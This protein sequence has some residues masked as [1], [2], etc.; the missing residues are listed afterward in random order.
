MVSAASNLAYAADKKAEFSFADALGLTLPVPASSGV[1]SAASN[2]AALVQMSVA[3]LTALQLHQNT[4]MPVFAYEDFVRT[5][6]SFDLDPQRK[7]TG[8]GICRFFLKGFCAKGQTCPYK[9]VN[10]AT[11]NA[12]ASKAGVVCKH[13]L[14]SLCKKGDLCEFLHEY[15]LKKMPECWFYSKYG[16]CSNP[17]CQYLHLDPESKIKECP[18]YARGFCKHGPKCRNKHVRQAVC[19]NYVTGFCPKGPDCPFGHPKFEL[20]TLNEDGTAVAGGHNLFGKKDNLC[21][22][23]KQPGHIAIDC[24]Q[25]GGKPGFKRDLSTIKCYNCQSFAAHTFNERAIYVKGTPSQMSTLDTATAA[26]AEELTKAVENLQ[27]EKRAL[28]AELQQIKKQAIASA[29]TA[30]AAAP[31]LQPAATATAPSL[32]DENARLRQDAEMLDMFRGQNASLKDHMHELAATCDAQRATVARLTHEVGVLRAAARTGESGAGEDGAAGTLPV[33]DDGIQTLIKEFEAVVSGLRAETARLEHALDASQTELAQEK[34]KSRKAIADLQA[35]LTA[36][37]PP[38]A[39]A[40]GSAVPTAVPVAATVKSWW[41]SKT[42]AASATSAGSSAQASTSHSNG[43][44]EISKLEDQIKAANSEIVALKSAKQEQSK[45][46][47]NF[48]KNIGRLREILSL[49]AKSSNMEASLQDV[50]DAVEKTRKATVENESLAK[51]AKDFEAKLS[52]SNQ[53]LAAMAKS[54]VEEKGECNELEISLTSANTQISSL[55]ASL[56]EQGERMQ[57]LLS[58]SSDLKANYEKAIQALQGQKDT[59]ISQYESAACA[60]QETIARKSL[61][62][63]QIKRNN[64]NGEEDG[65]GSEAVDMASSPEFEGLK[66]Q[67]EKDRRLAAEKISSLEAKISTLTTELDKIRTSHTEAVKEI[68]IQKVRETEAISDLELQIKKKNSELEVANAS[69]ENLKNQLEELHKSYDLAVAAA[70]AAKATE[71]NHAEEARQLKAELLRLQGDAANAMKEFESRLVEEKSALTESFKKE[72]ACLEEKLAEISG[73]K[74]KLEKDAAELKNT[75][76]TGLKSTEAEAKTLLEKHKKDVGILEERHKKELAE[77]SET[78][79]RSLADLE[80][81]LKKEHEEKRRKEI[82]EKTAKEKLLADEKLQKE[83]S[84]AEERF[85]KEKTK[86]QAD[87]DA[88]KAEVEKFKKEIASHEQQKTEQAKKFEKEL[89]SRSDDIGR[90]TTRIKTI[91]AE[92]DNYKAE[93][94][95]SIIDLNSKLTSANSTIFK[96]TEDVNEHQKKGTKYEA[97]ILQLRQDV[98]EAKAKLGIIAAE[99]EVS[100]S[101]SERLSNMNK[102]KDENIK[103]LR[104]KIDELIL[105]Q[106]NFAKAVTALENDKE[107]LNNSI[108]L[109]V[110]KLAEAETHFLE[111]QKEFA[112]SRQADLKN[113]QA[114]NEA[115]ESLKNENSAMSGKL[116]DS[117]SEYKAMEKRGAL[118]IKDLQKQII[119]ERR[120]Q[121]SHATSPENSI[122]SDSIESLSKTPDDQ[123]DLLISRNTGNVGVPKIERLTTELVQ[124]AKE[125]ETLNKRFKNAEEE[126]RGLHDRLAKQSEEL[127]LKSKAVQQYMLREYHMQL[128]PDDKQKAGVTMEALTSTSAMQKMNPALLA[129]VNIKMQ[130]LLEELTSKVMG[131]EEENRVLKIA[132]VP[133]G[134][135]MSAPK[136]PDAETLASLEQRID[137]LTSITTPF[138]SDGPLLRPGLESIQQSVGSI[139]GKLSQLVNERRVLGDF[140]QKYSQLKDIISSHTI[141]TEQNSASALDLDMGLGLDPASKKEIVLSAEEEILSLADQLREIDSLKIELDSQAMNGLDQRIIALNPIEYTQIAQSQASAALKEEFM[142]VLDEY[143]E[144]IE[145]LTQTF[146][147]YDSV[148]N[149]I[150][151]KLDAQVIAKEIS[152]IAAGGPENWAILGLLACVTI[153]TRK[154]IRPKQK[155]PNS[156][157]KRVQIVEKGAQGL[158]E[159]RKA[160]NRAAQSQTPVVGY[161]VHHNTPL[162]VRL[163]ISKPA[164]A[165]A[166]HHDVKVLLKNHVAVLNV[167]N[168]ERDLDDEHVEKVLE[169]VSANSSPAVSPSGGV[170]AETQLTLDGGE[171]DEME[172][173]NQLNEQFEADLKQVLNIKLTEQEKFARFHESALKD[174]IVGLQFQQRSR[175]MIDKWKQ[176]LSVRSSSLYEGW[177]SYQ[178]SETSYW[179]AKWATIEGHALVLHQDESKSGKGM[180]FPLSGV[181]ICVLDQD[182]GAIRNSFQLAYSGKPVHGSQFYSESHDVLCRIAAAVELSA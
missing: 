153:Q 170:A 26:T 180:L 97:D 137:Y 27:S 109:H 159:L 111:Q 156:K 106:S 129:Q 41:G 89:F 135:Q 54:I 96:L 56:T 122:V 110:K 9:H 30:V 164:R 127:E 7:S 90:Y 131:L 29:S 23:C 103:K 134:V 58:E 40:T 158:P 38:L 138:S 16:E 113:I 145:T 119:K 39:S 105:T 2:P 57:S 147:Y 130:R 152:S 45:S 37:S 17:E 162:K 78:S 19:Q 10:A 64:S 66:Q 169:T 160:M 141:T 68:E 84:E 28:E 51:A 104:Q 79:K 63:Q 178:S 136:P 146:L 73:Q 12:A 163:N 31:A 13:Y 34:E 44:S 65:S 161:V 93:T 42:P 25:G 81:R 139:R 77:L 8:E 125:N 62:L 151:A 143:N 173:E 181:Q 118:I 102:E 5:Q 59:L 179:K 33:S 74:E 168:L 69:K 116:K 95:K 132:E 21:F 126:I 32:V 100:R 4:V 157:T 71:E 166:K 108:A 72:K 61:E 82:D 176:I 24:P 50:I 91:E 60:M 112:F 47:E 148:L 155:G 48:T 120:R 85:K 52:I 133:A 98:Q 149:A 115:V 11:L 53:Q 83:K 36:A 128:Q 140:M 154:R 55:K 35:K 99:L 121:T 117:L 167:E 101:S 144:Y 43:I 114:L 182:G 175:A 1:L 67:Y 46:I 80:T 92:F 165:L 88:A 75:L 107:T 22:K 49:S 15:N 124:L 172:I 70:A 86:I 142:T 94:V 76:A 123:M 171:R 14:R 6:L 177:L 87:L 18:W 3:A 174:Q 20:P 150:T